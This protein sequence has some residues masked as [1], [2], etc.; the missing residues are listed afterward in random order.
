[1]Q[2]NRIVSFCCTVIFMHT[3]V[4]FLAYKKCQLIVEQRLHFL[5]LYT[6]LLKKAVHLIGKYQ[7]RLM[8][9]WKY[10][11]GRP[12]CYWNY[13]RAGQCVIEVCQGQASVSTYQGRP[14]CYTFKSYVFYLAVFLAIDC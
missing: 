12:V 10:T 11:W 14:V 8:C 2:F 7:D 6:F 5:Q 4:M 9:Y 1:M 3:V 13:T